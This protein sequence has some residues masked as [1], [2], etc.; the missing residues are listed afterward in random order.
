MRL[1]ENR[2]F[3]KIKLLV[4]TSKVKRKP[5]LLQK[6]GLAES[7]VKK[8]FKFNLSA[9][10]QLEHRFVA[11]DIYIDSVFWLIRMADSTSEEKRLF[12]RYVHLLKL[13]SSLLLTYHKTIFEKN[14]KWVKK[15]FIGK[16]DPVIT[17]KEASLS[18]NML[19]SYTHFIQKLDEKKDKHLTDW[20]KG[21]RF[22]LD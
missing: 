13:M 2:G 3:E 18:L 21:K 6:L 4:F 10:T 5:I 8:S 7:Q 22:D 16:G 11:A 20:L 19:I 15:E 12:N 14:G 17:F 9:V 1:K